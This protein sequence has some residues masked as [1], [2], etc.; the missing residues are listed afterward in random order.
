MGGSFEPFGGHNI[1][2][3]ARLGKA[4]IFGP[5]MENFAEEAA[6]LT[7]N[8]AG[9]QLPS[10]DALS[11]TLNELL[12]QPDKTATLGKNAARLIAERSGVIDDYVAAL[13]E[14]CPALGLPA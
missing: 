10:L 1:L 2:E 13:A 7:A 14:L 9:I 5:H 12:A 3:P 11:S 8:E 6:L 4:V